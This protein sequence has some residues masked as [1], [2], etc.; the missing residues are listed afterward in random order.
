M[1]LGGGIFTSG[2][3]ILPGSYI[4]FVSA[5]RAESA[6]SERG[7]VV[8]PLLLDWG[9]EAEI[10]FVTAKEVQ[11]KSIKIFGYEYENERLKPIRDIFCNATK[12]YFY[13]LNQSAVKASNVYATAKYGGSRGND[14]RIVI[15]RNLDD[16]TMF[17]VKVLFDNLLVDNQVVPDTAKLTDND[18]VIWKKDA[19]LEETAGISMTG[20]TNGADA[21]GEDYQD[22][23]NK[24]ESLSFHVLGCPSSNT[25][26][27][28]LFI[29]FTKRLRDEVGAKFQTVI[30]QGEADYEGIISVENSVSELNENDPAY[31][32]VYWVSGAAAGCAIN[33]TNT[34][35]VYNGEYEITTDYTQKQ[36]EKLLKTGK[37]IMH[38]VGQSIRVLSDI[39][40]LTT[41]T[42]NKGSDFASNQTIRVLDQIGNDIAYL[43]QQKY[44][45][46]APNDEMGRTALWNELVNY[47]TQLAATRAIE[48]VDS[49]AISVTKGDTKKSVIVT[50]PVAPLNAMEQLY[51]TCIVA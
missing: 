11:E 24:I 13:R 37:F 17:E 34:N 44:L 47:Y 51:M 12:L 31:G 15:Q 1:A 16:N 18:F 50:C 21:T 49:A 33:H 6:L 20:G 9:I 39:N 36:L 27:V 3:K 5:A 8:I 35:K 30:Y 41:F 45:G 25:S 48:V 40:T 28:S 10:S 23:L 29:A 38:M 19:E 42:A 22:F 46:T 2:D 14:I 4:N 26:I 7:I 43:F 32:L